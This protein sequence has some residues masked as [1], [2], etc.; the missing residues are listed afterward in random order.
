MPEVV[1]LA[2]GLEL[3]AADGAPAQPWRVA[4]AS[5]DFA[6]SILACAE[7]QDGVEG[8]NGVVATHLAPDQIVVTLSLEFSDELRTPQIEEAVRAVEARIHEKHQE[9]VAA[10]S[11][12]RVT[13]VL[14]KRWVGE[15]MSSHSRKLRRDGLEA[16]KPPRRLNSRRACR[17]APGSRAE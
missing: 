5:S 9:V 2:P 17:H 4:A 3:R 12:R 6:Q 8:A 14:R 10:L 11:N 16:G 1:R 13:R 7:A 15:T